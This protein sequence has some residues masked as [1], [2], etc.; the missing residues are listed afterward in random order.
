MDL[1]DFFG[2]TSRASRPAA[3]PG[4]RL[5]CGDGGAPDPPHDGWW[6]LPAGRT[7][8]P[9]TGEPRQRPARRTAGAAGGGARRHVHPLRRRP[10]VLVRRRPT[11]RRRRTSWPRRRR[12]SGQQ[13]Y[14]LHLDRKLQIRRRHHRQMV[15][16]LVVN[17][18]VALPRARRRWL[19]AVEHHVY[20]GKP[21]SLSRDQLTGWQAFEAMIVS[22]PPATAD[23][24]AAATATIALPWPTDARYYLTTSIAYANNKPGLHTLYEVIGADAIARWHRMLGDDT[25]FL[26]GTD[27]H[28]INIAQ[29][30]VDEGRPTREF[31]DEK[32]A[33]FRRPRRPSRSRPDRFIRTTDPDHIRSAQEMVRRAHANGDIYLGT[34]EGWYCPNEGFRN[35]TDVQETARGD[36]LP[37]PSRRPA[38]V[39]D[40]AQ[41]VLPAVGLPG[42]ARAP[43]RRPP[44]VRPAGLPA[45]RD[46]RLHPR[47]ARGLLDQPRADARRLGDPVPDRRERRDRRCARTARGT[48]RRARSTSGSTRS[49]TTSPGPASPTT[50]TR[51]RTGGR[52]TCTSSART[53]PGSTRSSGRPCCGAPGS[54]R[55]A[56]SGSTA[57]CWRP[58]A[59]G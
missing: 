6:R 5:G 11:M 13:G 21:A 16:G 52:P 24:T 28:S 58:A 18:Q 39:A 43:L 7:D 36:D 22:G 37:E 49:S 57:G 10:D 46:A 17:D 48:R 9:A 34:Y 50:P 32:V 4:A 55:R 1:V 41:L 8:Q 47:R 15:T 38:P 45:Q 3:V 44:R 42:A 40:R 20:S 30:A 12:S 51:S 56:R 2:S 59:S 27:E 19:R 33:M 29:A 54:R 25:R 35:A 14:R 53:S 23:L 26:T 31:V